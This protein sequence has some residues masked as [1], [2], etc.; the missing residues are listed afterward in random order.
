MRRVVGA[1]LVFVMLGAW[2]L[3]GDWSLRLREHR[4]IPSAAFYVIDSLATGVT[5]APRAPR[6]TPPRPVPPASFS[7]QPLAFLSAAPADSLDL[8]PGV[9]PVLARR[10]IEARAARGGFTCWEDVLAI[11]GIGPRT[12]ARWQSLAAGQ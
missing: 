11:R 2:H 7:R 3:S 1:L 5:P 9:G 12:V 8:L 6:P 4:D 10:I